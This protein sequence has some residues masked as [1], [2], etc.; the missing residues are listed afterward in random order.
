MDDCSS[1]GCAPSL[2][3][4]MLQRGSDVGLGRAGGSKRA[5]AGARGG[6]R[7]SLVYLCRVV[8][9]TVARLEVQVLAVRQSVV[10][11][12]ARRDPR[13]VKVAGGGDGWLWTTLLG[14]LAGGCWCGAA[15]Q[16]VSPCLWSPMSAMA[17]ADFR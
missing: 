14:P 11:E 15:A 2:K 5:R 1:P 16:S 17:P 4:A 9:S 8:P 6:A 13:S 7:K 3:G 10:V 12:R